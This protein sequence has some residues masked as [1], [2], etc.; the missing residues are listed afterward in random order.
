MHHELLIDFKMKICETENCY[1]YKLCSQL[2]KYNFLPF[3]AGNWI[4]PLRT[5]NTTYKRNTYAYIINENVYMNNKSF[6]KW[7][8]KVTPL[9][10]WVYS[11]F[12]LHNVLHKSN[13]NHKGLT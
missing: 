5:G 1:S 12:Y 13:I 9:C 8:I 3:K 7:K 2:T 4:K 6:L 10:T 11:R